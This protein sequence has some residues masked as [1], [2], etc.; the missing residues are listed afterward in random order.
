MSA[1]IDRD[2]VIVLELPSEVAP[3]ERSLTSHLADHRG[4]HA[5]WQESL[6]ESPSW[7]ISL[8]VH[9]VAFLIVTSLAVPWTPPR[10]GGSGTIA[11]TLGFA[12]RTQES[13]GP[14]V[15]IES[16]SAT[17]QES[18]AEQATGTSGRTTGDQA[19]PSAVPPAASSSSSSHAAA[20]SASSTSSARADRSAVI[21]RQ[22]FRPSPY[23][24]LLNRRRPTLGASPAAVQALQPLSDPSADP[25]QRELDRVVDD[26][27]AYDI[28]QLRGA[29]GAAACGRFSKLGPEALPALVRGLNKAAGIHASCPVGVIA[30]K[31]LT[32]LRT[33]NDPSLL[34]YAI[35][36]VGVGVPEDA[37]HYHRLVALRKNWLGAPQMPANVATVVDRLESRQEGELMELM[38]ALSDAPSD[39]VVAALRSGDEYLGAAAVL[40]IIQG[41][42]IWD[43]QQRGQLRAAVMHFQTTTD[44]AQIRSLAV[45][46][47][48]VLTR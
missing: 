16:P 30:G 14:Q 4:W 1:S 8:I 21:E 31:L 13:Q 37:P 40:A 34:Q 29:A 42:H 24:A 35:N 17:A 32:T 45:D 26:F 10:A 22:A 2:R 47:Q 18:P 36:N 11:L 9:L 15:T 43:V 28:G 27:I 19:S 5:W 7:L 3:A 38:L 25:Q 39:T 41:P 33:A 20:E 23:A 48:R 44:N 12:D 46:A 6:H